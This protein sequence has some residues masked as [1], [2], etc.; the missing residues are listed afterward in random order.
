MAIPIRYRILRHITEEPS[1]VDVLAAQVGKSKST[2]RA[3]LRRLKADGLDI[4]RDWYG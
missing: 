4:H 2:V 1:S 3:A